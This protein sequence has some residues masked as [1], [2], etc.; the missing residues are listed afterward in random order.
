MTPSTTARPAPGLTRVAGSLLRPFLP[1]YFYP[2][3]RADFRDPG[4]R[5]FLRSL[6]PGL[7]P[8]EPAAALELRR[9][10][11][12]VAGGRFGAHMQVE[13]LNDGPVTIIFDSAE[14]ERPRRG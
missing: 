10:G 4:T 14:L 8:E 9:L 13:I 6:A 2:L 7:D 5:E 3:R 12:R 11:V 1:R